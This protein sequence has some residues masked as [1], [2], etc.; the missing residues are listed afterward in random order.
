MLECNVASSADRCRGCTRLSLK[1]RVGGASN[2]GHSGSCCDGVSRWY[3]GPI[4]L[5][6]GHWVALSADGLLQQEGKSQQCGR[7]DS[8]NRTKHCR[9]EHREGQGPSMKGH[10]W[11]WLWFAAS[12]AHADPDPWD[13]PRLGDGACDIETRRRTAPPGEGNE[14]VQVLCKKEPH[15]INVEAG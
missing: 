7:V 10:P 3:S 1:W 11:R 13:K 15:G 6:G 8:R 2:I 12:Q 14:L 4:R 9:N 5:E